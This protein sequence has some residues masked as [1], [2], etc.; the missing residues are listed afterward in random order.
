MKFNQMT[1]EEKR[2]LLIAMYF[3]QKGAHQLNRLHD[4]FSRKDNDNEIKEVMEKESNLFQAIA[5]FNDFYLYSE[6]ETENEEID[7]L[8]NEIFEWIEDHGFTED[9][10]KFFDKN[11]IMFS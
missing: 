4:E 3:L 2:K 1:D 7:K 10:K 5:R 8:E 9:I 11:S 6:N